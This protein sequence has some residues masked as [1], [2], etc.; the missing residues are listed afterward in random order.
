MAR[1]VIADKLNTI[2]I[3]YSGNDI[4]N[5]RD[6]FAIMQE[7]AYEQSGTVEGEEISEDVIVTIISTID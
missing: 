5:V 6:D 1:T 2:A 3:E 4:H 7:K